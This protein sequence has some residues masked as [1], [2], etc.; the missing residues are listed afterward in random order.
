MAVK[1]YFKS[2]KCFQ[3]S[4]RDFLTSSFHERSP[5]KQTKPSSS[6]LLILLKLDSSVCR[7]CRRAG[8]T[9]VSDEGGSTCAAGGLSDFMLLALRMG[10]SVAE[11]VSL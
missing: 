1:T 7:R 2:F 10:E 6:R 8:V 5:G 4:R 9:S 11:A 3:I